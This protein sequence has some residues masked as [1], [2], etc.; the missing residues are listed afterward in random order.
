VNW[1]PEL[2]SDSHFLAQVG[3]LKMEPLSTDDSMELFF[4]KVGCKTEFSEHLKKYTEEIIRKCSGLPLAIIIVASV[5][6]SQPK[7]SELWSHIKEF[8]SSR[9]NLSSKE[10]LREIIGLS[11][12]TLPQ[13][14][15]TYLIS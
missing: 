6:A 12:C 4:N 3:I 8:L 5:L 10:L 7:S 1:A 13:Q 11:Y 15:K 14:V 2:D 9:N